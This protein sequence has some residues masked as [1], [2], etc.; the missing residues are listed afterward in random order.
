MEKI[1]RDDENKIRRLYRCI[2]NYA[3]PKRIMYDGVEDLWGKKNLDSPEFPYC[4]RSFGK[5]PWYTRTI[6]T[7]KLLTIPRLL[8]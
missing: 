5:D 7:Q 6:L 3:L 1:D 2:S 8:T 4:N